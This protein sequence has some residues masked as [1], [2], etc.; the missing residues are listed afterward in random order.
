MMYLNRL[1]CDVLEEMRKCHETRCYGHLP[2]L[3][4]EAQTMANRMEAGLNDKAD[5]QDLYDEKRKLHKEVKKLKD[6]L[7]ALEEL[8]EDLAA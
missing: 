7:K 3:I 2:G 8:K 1:L 6:E 4:E 5:I